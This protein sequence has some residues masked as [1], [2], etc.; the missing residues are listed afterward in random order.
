MK[1]KYK[2]MEVRELVGKDIMIA[3]DGNHLTNDFGYSC[4]NFNVK[5]TFSRNRGWSAFENAG[6]GSENDEATFDFYTKNPKNISCFV[7]YN[8]RGKIQGRRMFFKGPSLINDD[9]FDVPLKMGEEVKYL[10]GY[11]GA[12]EREPQQSINRAVLD[13]YSDSIIYTDRGVLRNGKIDDGITNHWIMG[14][15]NTEFSKYPPVDF[16]YVSIK[17][18][19][20]SNFEPKK[21]IKDIL[22]R[23]FKKEGIE[24]DAAYRFK[25]GAK[26]VK[27]DYTTWDTHKGVIKNMDDY[28]KI[29]QE[30]DEMDIDSLE[31]GDKVR[32]RGRANV[33][34]IVKVDTDSVTLKSDKYEWPISKD[35]LKLLFDKI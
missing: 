11:Y 8:D 14:V 3:Y 26:K 12:H 13:K 2:T 28:T 7:C 19:S 16:L 31:V 20:L 10:Y 18:K 15:E 21:Y 22:E 9:E 1:N 4:A 27:Y 24:F 35:R 5:D 30:I 25:P 34:T 6:N 32:S 29:V 23:D 33:C 17:L